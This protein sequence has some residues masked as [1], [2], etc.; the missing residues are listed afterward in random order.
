MAIHSKIETLQNRLAG[1]PWFSSRRLQY[2]YFLLGALVVFVYSRGHVTA[3]ET[4][5]QA[6]GTVT[7]LSFSL[8]MVIRYIID[9]WF[10]FQDPNL[11]IV[12]KEFLISLGLYLLAGISGY[13]LIVGYFLPEEQIPATKYLI[14]CLVYGYFVAVDNALNT[15]RRCYYERRYIYA[16]N[17]STTS[18]SSRLRLFI[19]TTILITV[20][21][22]YL[23][24]NSVVYSLLAESGP[25]Q[26]D[27]QIIFLYDI[28]LMTMVIIGF[29]MR[30]AYT[31]AQNQKYLLDTQIKALQ[32]IQKGDLDS[33]VPI[34]SKDEFALIAQNTNK[35]LEELR[36]KQ[37][38]TS[39]LERI[40]S[41]DI[42]Q[43]L[44]ADDAAM[45]KQGQ[46]YEVAILFCDLRRFTSFVET[47]PP[48]QVIRFLN[49]FFSKISDLV[50]T[51]NGLVNKFMGDAILGVFGAANKETSMQD[52]LQ[53]ALH[54]ITHTKT[55]RLGDADAFDIGIGIH[56]GFAV[57]GTIG[58]ADRYEYTFI[59]DV[60][61]T[62]SRLD[63]LSK[64]LGYRII[65]SDDAYELL[66]NDFKKRFVD[67]GFQKIRGKSEAV[68]V[69]GAITD[70]ELYEL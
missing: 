61:N 9:K 52:A 55:I 30:V 54:I 51:H 48:D 24:A 14:G 63:G 45:L 18:S 27:I 60:V 66:N 65:I 67:L 21:A 33:Y 3:M 22:M 23:S 13:A 36:E 53:A 10:F 6:L 56:T 58:S 49:A 69:Y 47:T 31:Y 28:I 29:S 37:K 35:M 25:D 70:A 8:V 4:S 68:H 12:N 20:V 59:G 57:A 41:P 15:E 26:R 38:V 50:S 11:E 17:V 42:M 64:R 44:L 2:L 34:M 5:G 46:K 43:R 1:Q 62:A 40:V 39:V 7:L 19:L 16:K 32:N